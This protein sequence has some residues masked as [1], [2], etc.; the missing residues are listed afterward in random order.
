MI[1]NAILAAVAIAAV[2]VFLYSTSD[3]GT[4]P[5]TVGFGQVVE[6]AQAGKID[7]VDVDGTTLTVTY[8]SVAN[9]KAV[10][11]ESEAGHDR[12]TAQYAGSCPGSNPVRGPRSGSAPTD[13]GA[14]HR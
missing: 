12:A 10:V 4:A 5:T 1:R 7:T 11:V 6:D 2:L 13:A 8:R 9:A 3:A 14:G